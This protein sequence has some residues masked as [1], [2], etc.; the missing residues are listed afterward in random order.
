M[1]DA[2]LDAVVSEI[3]AA[4]IGYARPSMI[5]IRDTGKPIPSCGDIY[6][7]VHELPGKSGGEN[8]LDERFSFG[9]TLT[10]R[11]QGIPLDR[12]GDKLLAVKLAKST[13][14]NRRADRLKNLL[15]MD[16]NLLKLANNYLVEVNPDAQQVYGFCEPGR[17]RGREVPVLVGPEWFDA[18]PTMDEMG[19]KSELRFDDARRMQAL[20]TFT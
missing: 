7:A 20:G 14:F 19:L 18:E 17:Y 2:L 8:S 15:H 10:M 4:Q 3:V 11:L 16:W 9:V 5:D 12:I 1:I 13:G 6:V